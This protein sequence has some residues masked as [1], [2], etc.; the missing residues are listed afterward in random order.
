MTDC[1]DSPDVKRSG[2][3]NLAGVAPSSRAKA[4]VRAKSNDKPKRDTDHINRAKKSDADAEELRNKTRDWNRDKIEEYL[5]KN[6]L[7]PETGAALLHG[8]DAQK[9]RMGGLKTAKA[10]KAV[11]ATRDKKLWAEFCSM[12]DTDPRNRANL[13]A[14]KYGISPQ[15]V[16]RIVRNMR[17]R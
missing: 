4:S 16:R 2:D 12:P 14:K 11:A 9:S 5:R 13:L 10:Q 8:L 15:S 7:G 3:F 1:R 17:M 6:P